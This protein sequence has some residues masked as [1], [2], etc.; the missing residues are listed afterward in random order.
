MTEI[1]QNL[2]GIIGLTIGVPALFC[3]FARVYR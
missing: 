2:L 1:V 3:L